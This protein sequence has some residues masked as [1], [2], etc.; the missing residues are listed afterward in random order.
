MKSQSVILVADD[1]PLMRSM[2]ARHLARAGFTVEECADGVEAF[3]RLEKQG[4]GAL[5]VLDYEMPKFNGAQVCEIVRTHSDA[6]VAQTPIIL[7][8]GH[9]GE[10]QEI[11]C[12]KAG[13][14][15]FVTKPVNLP[16]LKARIETHLR[17]AALRATLRAQNRELELWRAAHER[18]LEAARA[19]QQAIVPHGVPVLEGWDFA[20]R[21]RPLIQVGGDIFD[22]LPVPEDNL[23]V[24]IADATGHGVAA[25][26]LTTFTKLLFHHAATTTFAPDA[27][28][29]RVN[30]DFHAILRG[31]S[32][33]TAA[34]VRLS[35]GQGTVEMAG[36][37]HP[38]VVV[39]RRGGAMET[40]PSGAP[41]LGLLDTAP[42]ERKQT[43]LNPGDALLLFTDG[44][45]GVTNA[46]G[47]H[48]SFERFTSG[49]ANQAH[50]TAEA[51]V[52]TALHQAS[53]FAGDRPFDDDLA[54]VAMQ[55]VERKVPDA[56]A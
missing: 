35:P 44:L 28:L 48:L 22:W 49:L 17:L 20:V 47:E 23:L 51:L 39:I 11:E 14:D 9:T 3:Q 13:A 42:I 15:D 12:L 27:V 19:I 6:A 34:C 38:P 56:S 53:A 25:A 54:L 41:P 29:N 45:Y 16:V 33:M 1:D 18:D 52:E 46:A 32:F 26:L 7:L 4:G 30:R 5:L 31:H 21:H 8:T 37:G 40:F 50:P 55:R 24:W 10:Q 2:L 43:V 36:A